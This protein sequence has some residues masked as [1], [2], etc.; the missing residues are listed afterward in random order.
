MNITEVVFLSS[1]LTQLTINFLFIVGF[2]YRIYMLGKMASNKN[3]T[4]R[5][6]FW[7]KIT[8]LSILVI[9]DVAELILSLTD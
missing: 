7:I 2:L 9:T 8:L 6:S 4:Y 1:Y 5:F 3:Q